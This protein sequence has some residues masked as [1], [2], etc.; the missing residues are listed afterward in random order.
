MQEWLVILNKCLK[1]GRRNKAKPKA[2]N[3]ENFIVLK[4]SIHLK[5]CGSK[6]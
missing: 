4:A 6:Q 1:S 2:Q 3:L 5:R